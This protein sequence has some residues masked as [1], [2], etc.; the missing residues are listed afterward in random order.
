VFT[1][2]ILVIFFSYTAKYMKTDFGPLKEGIGKKTSTALFAFIERHTHKDDVFIFL[3]PRVLSLFTGRNAS[4]YHWPKNK[5]TLLMY[6]E[7]IGASHV[8]VRPVY[9]RAIDRFIGEHQEIFE[10]IYTNSDFK[11]YRFKYKQL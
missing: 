11:V 9:E 7:K 10:L 4:I 8:I 1:F 6:F 2:L 5:K 3:K